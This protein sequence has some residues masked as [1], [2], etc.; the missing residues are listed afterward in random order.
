[1]AHP[2]S[3]TALWAQYL[4][5]RLAAM[6]LT[7]LDPDMNL[8]TASALGRAAYH[9]DHRHRQ[10][11]IRHLQMSFPEL[12]ASQINNLAKRSFEHL[13]KL[14][15]EVCQTPR[16][17]H[18]DSWGYRIQL[19]NIERAVELLN[20]NKPTIFITGHYGNWEVMGYLMAVLGYPIDALARPIDNPLI[21]D[22]L[23][24]V[25]QRHGMRIITKW[26]AT[27]EMLNTLQSG[28]SLGF[29]ADQNAGE[30]GIFVPF[31]GRLAST[32]KSIG[33]LAL[34]YNIPIVCSYTR[35]LKTGMRYEVGNTDIIY[36]EDCLTRRILFFTLLLGISAPS[37]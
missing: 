26:D 5:A 21:N 29:V 23:L 2:S 35:R 33:L 27:D 9:L 28:G 12:S 6:G 15:V 10:R 4:I 30:K 3:P 17:I 36:P 16:L 1:M 32:Y 13:S 34:K 22:W 31:F 24:G 14:V 11:T 37:K 18:K 25:R 7:S 19:N 8:R 20:D